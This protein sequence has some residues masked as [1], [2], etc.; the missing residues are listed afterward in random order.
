[1]TTSVDELIT[2]HKIFQF[3]GLIGMLVCI[4][5][6]HGEPLKDILFFFFAA[7]F[8]LNLVGNHVINHLE[9]FRDE[10]TKNA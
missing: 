8:A 7:Y 10:A 4:P 9:M 5:S 6:W 1:M 3:I 2:T